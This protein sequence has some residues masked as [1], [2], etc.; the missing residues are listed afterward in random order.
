[1][2][3]LNFNSVIIPASNSVL[4]F[5]SW[6]KLSPQGQRD[7]V[8]TRRGFQDN[9]CSAA[10]IKLSN[11]SSPWPLLRDLWPPTTFQNAE[12]GEVQQSVCLF[13]CNYSIVIYNCVFHL[14]LCVC[15]CVCVRARVCVCVCVC[16]K[17]LIT[18]KCIICLFSGSRLI[19]SLC[20]FSDDDASLKLLATL[21]YGSRDSNDCQL[22]SQVVSSNSLTLIKHWTDCHEPLHT[23]RVNCYNFSSWEGQGAR[24]TYITCIFV[25]IQV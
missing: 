4:T 10:K 3:K 13:A 5:Y 22:F 12:L 16:V 25:N 2:H 8:P 6:V 7:E 23:L 14:Y 19:W 1:M 20:S 18:F 21:R 24:T 9:I 11:N 15:V 17:G